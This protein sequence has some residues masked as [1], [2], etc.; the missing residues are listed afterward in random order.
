VKYSTMEFRDGNSWPS[1]TGR[2]QPRAC[3]VIH[4]KCLDTVEDRVDMCISTGQWLLP[5]KSGR[6]DHSSWT[7]SPGLQSARSRA[8][9]VPNPRQRCV[10]DLVFK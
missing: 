3:M 5:C 7:A 6:T 9:V 10:C 1:K 4:F 2:D 8:Y